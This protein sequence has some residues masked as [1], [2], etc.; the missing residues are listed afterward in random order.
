MGRGPGS[1]RVPGTGPVSWGGCLVVPPN[2]VTRELSLSFAKN[3]SLTFAAKIALL[4]IGVFNSIIL[5]RALGAGGKGL[6]SLGILSAA[7]IFNFANMGV[8]TASGYFLGRKKVNLEVLAG[9]WL[10]LSVIIGVIITGIS[11]AAA[12]AV[13]RF[14]LPAVPFNVIIISLLSIPFLVFVYN[15]QMLFRANSDFKSFN[16][17]EIIQKLVFLIVFPVFVIFFSRSR[18]I[19]AISVYTFS[20][21]VMALVVSVKW[22]RVIRLRFR[23]DNNLV[24]STLRFGIQGHFANILTFLNLRLDMLLINFFLN[25]AAV[26]FYSISVM[27]SERIWYFPD[28]LGIV[29][30]P[31][32]AH[33][34]DVEANMATAAV[35]RQAVMIV[36]ACNLGVLLFGK[37][38]IGLLYT[39][40]F[41]AALNPLF[42]L[43]PGVLAAS[44]SRILSGDLLAR[45]FPK[46]NMWAGA[47]SLFINIVCNVIL[48]PEI[49]IS[50]AALATS[51]SYTVHLVIIIVFYVRM[52]GVAAS[53]LLIPTVSDL[54]LF[55]AAIR[56][57]LGYRRGSKRHGDG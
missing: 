24:W 37:F 13:T 8:G 50:G 7:V 40:L 11:I 43:L 38:A 54:R 57:L 35:C 36:I 34:N 44:I 22:S 1:N 45:G 30:F 29:L 15:F 18:V 23:W 17:I 25:P 3:V 12:P 52:T 51:I 56:V 31:R 21:I 42:L 14:V 49:G 28:S 39:D 4:I 5:V 53:E 19:L 41:L 27:I 6:F 48:I 46:V 16:A 32:V 55:P 33:G 47:F 10:S 9:N 2:T 26:G 20:Y